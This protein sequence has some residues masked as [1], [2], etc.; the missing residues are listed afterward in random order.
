MKTDLI[1]SCI[2]SRHS[3]RYIGGTSFVW[4][5][6]PDFKQRILASHTIKTWL[7][8]IGMTSEWGQWYVD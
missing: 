8:D 4:F 3:H 1:F 2:P 6:P 5:R 7:S